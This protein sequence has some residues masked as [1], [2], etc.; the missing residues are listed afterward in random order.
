LFVVRS[1]ENTNALCVQSVRFFSVNTAGTYSNLATHL[2]GLLTIQ[3]SQISVTLD[4]KKL[5]AI[6]VA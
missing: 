4:S 3:K 6:C 2:E 1:V 5:L